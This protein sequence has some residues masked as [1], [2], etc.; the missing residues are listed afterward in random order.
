MNHLLEHGH[1]R[2]LYLREQY[3]QYQSMIELC[4]KMDYYRIMAQ[5]SLPIPPHWRIDYPEGKIEE[6]LELTFS[7]DPTPTALIVSDQQVATVFAFLLKHNLSIGKDVSVVA[8]DGIS[9]LN[10]ISPTVSTAV[11]DCIQLSE[12]VW[13]M[14]ERQ[15]QGSEDF[16][17]K[18]VK[19]SFRQG[20]SS[21][22]IQ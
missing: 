15:F 21:G 17:C 13:N 1:R 9:F 19:V 6:T 22:R 2:I 4:R 12:D 8:T 20:E 11:A 3:A 18:E 7:K 14:L 5:N 10:S 16:E